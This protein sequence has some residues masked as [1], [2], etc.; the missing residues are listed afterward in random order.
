MLHECLRTALS[1]L[2]PSLLC[3]PASLAS[4]LAVSKFYEKY[5]G[6]IWI[7]IVVV[8][9]VNCAGLFL[10]PERARSKKIEAVA[11]SLSLT[12]RRKPTEA[13]KALAIGCYLADVGYRRFV[14]NVVEAARTEELDLT[15][16]DYQYTLGRGKS[17]TL[18]HQTITRMQSPFLKLPTFILF[19]ETFFAKMGKMLGRSD[20]NF[21]ESPEFSKKYVLR[22]EDEAAIRA[23]FSPALRQALVPLQQLTVEGAADLLFVFRVERRTEPEELSA[24]IE[25]GKRILALFV[26]AQRSSA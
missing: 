7:W 20:I 9:L 5:S 19:P 25:E 14:S 21:P 24:S 17:S 22:G 10:D 13:D 6:Y 11:S 23:I 15:L 1:L 18:G 4:Q 12:F 26:E 3:A 8:I 2:A 16:F